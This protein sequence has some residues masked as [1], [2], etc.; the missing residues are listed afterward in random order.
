VESSAR[1]RLLRR[2][3]ARVDG[4]HLALQRDGLLHVAQPH[5]HLGEPRAREE[6]VRVIVAEELL[7]RR[8]HVA[9]VR[10]GPLS[11]APVGQRARQVGAQP[12]DVRVRRPELLLQ[13]GQQALV[14]L[15][16]PRLGHS[17]EARG[18]GELELDGA[19]ELRDRD[20]ERAR[21]LERLLV[22]PQR[23]PVVGQLEAGRRGVVS[24]AHVL[25]VAGRELR[26][27]ELHRLEQEVARALEVARAPQAAR[28]VLARAQDE[29]GAAPTQALEVGQELLQLR[30]RLRDALRAHERARLHEPRLEQ[31][32]RERRQVR[33]AET[34]PVREGLGRE[35]VERDLRGPAPDQE[36]ELRARPAVDRAVRTEQHL[37]QLAAARTDLAGRHLRQVQTDELPLLDS[38]HVEWQ[39]VHGVAHGAGP[40][41]RE[42]DGQLPRL[43]VGPHHAGDRVRGGGAVDAGGTGAVLD[44]HARQ[45]GLGARPHDQL[46]ARRD[47]ELD[48]PAVAPVREAL[49]RRR[50]PGLRGALRL[51]RDRE[52]ECEGEHGPRA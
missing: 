27:G 35:A 9:R 6:R 41:R 17:H 13:R 7:A 22:E 26:R 21:E 36:H 16:E 19:L 49:L 23:A 5:E 29:Q 14:L 50:V 44:P 24:Q 33:G 34:V 15:G 4:E 38:V 39:E 30:A 3:R 18:Q 51:G 2:E 8:Q 43:D 12:Q 20:R 1:K 28:K 25:G 11:L 10:Q 42:R 31:A 40:V 32:A 52:E 45:P 37:D 46:R 47:R 48:D